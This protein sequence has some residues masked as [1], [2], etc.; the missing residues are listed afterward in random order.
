MA[1]NGGLSLRDVVAPLL[2]DL[3]TALQQANRCRT[4][5]LPVT[6][7]R[8]VDIR[9]LRR[10]GRRRRESRHS[11][12]FFPAARSSRVQYNGKIVQSQLDL[13]DL[14]P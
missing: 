4:T 6:R 14:L 12:P 5:W 1:T 7:G 8:E 9:D 10:R 3:G 2:H 11:G 13:R